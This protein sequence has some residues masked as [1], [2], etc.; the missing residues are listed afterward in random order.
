MSEPVYAATGKTIGSLVFF[1]SASENT[2]RFVANCELQNE[3]INVYRIPL[4]P[5]DSA[6]QV[7][8][9]YILIVPTYGGGNLRNAVPKQVIK[10][11]NDP[12]NRKY[13]QGVIASGNTNFGEGYCA[14]GDVI[15]AKCHVPFMYR[16]E[17]M[18][19]PKDVET[20]RHGVVDFFKHHHDTNNAP[21]TT[22]SAEEIST[23]DTAS[24]V[25]AST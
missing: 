13:I 16:F 19:T 3:G 11:L 22:M 6:L 9:P 18:G 4:R 7:R 2:A 14:A 1:S 17:L 23:E 24:V 8:E 10:F 12:D 25:A 21:N 20:V 15:S 5:N